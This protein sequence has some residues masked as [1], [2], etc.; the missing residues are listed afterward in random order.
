M[1]G[2][3]KFEMGA[4]TPDELKAD[5]TKHGW[6]QVAKGPARVIDMHDAWTDVYKQF[7]RIVNANMSNPDRIEQKVDALY[8]QHRGEK[9]WDEAYR[10]WKESTS[11]RDIQKRKTFDSMCRPLKSYDVSFEKNGV[12][13]IYTVK[14]RNLQEAIKLAQKNA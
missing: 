10:R 12:T 7:E 4:T 6:H 3:T 14:A 1:W 2:Y 13:H 9:D 5:L 8:A 11:M